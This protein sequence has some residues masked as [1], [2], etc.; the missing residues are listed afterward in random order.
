MLL[1][2]KSISRE[3]SAMET[4]TTPLTRH[5][6]SVCMKTPLEITSASLVHWSS[7]GSSKPFIGGLCSSLELTGVRFWC[8]TALPSSALLSLSELSCLLVESLQTR[9]NVFMNSSLTRSLKRRLLSS[10]NH[11]ERNKRRN[12]MNVSRKLQ[13]KLARGGYYISQQKN[14]LIVKAHAATVL[15]YG[16]G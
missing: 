4:D 14:A 2:L 10:R 3:S 8:T 7:S 11:S 9:R 13:K 12:T 1:T 6:T 16:A 15:E 5:T